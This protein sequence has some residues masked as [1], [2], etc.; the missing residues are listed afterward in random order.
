MIDLEAR[1]NNIKK[2]FD[3]ERILNRDVKNSENI[4]KYYRLNRPIYWLFLSRHGFVH[5]ASRRGRSSMINYYA[6]ADFISKYIKT[7]DARMVLELGAGK[8]GNLKYLA[9]KHREV[10]FVGLDLPQGQF[11][12]RYFNDYKNIKALYADYHEL[13]YFDDDS[14]DLIYI[15]EALVHARNQLKVLKEAR[16]VLRPHGLLIIVQDNLIMPV[17][18]LQSSERLAFKLSHAGVMAAHDSRHYFDLTKNLASA[19]MGLMVNKDITADVMPGLE[20]MDRQASWFIH[21]PKL[22]RTINKVLPA[23]IA[24]NSITPYLLRPLFE[25]GVLKYHLTVARKLN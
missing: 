22:L 15:V 10:K 3:I 1:L 19:G 17:R 18:K 13:K 12:I 9:S 6:P 7:N 11:K 14:I 4:A 16:R 2:I 23:E 24:G 5:L 8:G 25:R 20:R 21:H